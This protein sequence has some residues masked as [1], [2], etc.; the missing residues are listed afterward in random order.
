MKLWGRSV[1]SPARGKGE[2]K[3]QR[4]RKKEN[5]PRKKNYWG[6]CG[7]VNKFK[8]VS[9]WGGGGRSIPRKGRSPSQEKR[10]GMMGGVS[11][12]NQRNNTLT[13]PTSG[14]N[15]LEEGGGEERRGP[16][17]FRGNRE[18][19][20]KK[21]RLRTFQGGKVDKLPIWGKERL[22]KERRISGRKN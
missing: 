15:Y 20:G 14:G 9:L 13:P 21:E 7:G 11:I 5:N 1:L 2:Q 10:K 3:S 16:T 19:Y 17:L 22:K 4:R 8:E 18:E 6:R 12:T